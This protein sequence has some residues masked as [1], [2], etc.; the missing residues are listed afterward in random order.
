MPTPNKPQQLHRIIWD[1]GPFGNYHRI[2]P[3]INRYFNVRSCY[4]STLSFIL[5][6]MIESK[7]S[8]KEYLREH[9]TI[10]RKI[11]A[12][13]I[14]KVTTSWRGNFIIPNLDELELHVFSYSFQCSKHYP[15][16]GIRHC[17][18]DN[19]CELES[20]NPFVIVPVIKP[21]A[22]WY[23]CRFFEVVGTHVCNA[24]QTSSKLGT[25]Q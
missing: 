15:C 11:S 24:R 23:P 14:T 18:D 3:Q 22:W 20:F 9:C 2:V 13:K 6:I 17:S 7:R 16:C 1:A 19:T 4:A 8:R 5:E 21:E 25:V 12:L 10:K